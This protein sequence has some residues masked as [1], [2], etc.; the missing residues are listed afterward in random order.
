MMPAL[1][2]LAQKIFSIIVAVGSAHDDV[3]MIPV[4][5][6]EPWK[7]LAGLVIKFDDD[8]R[9]MN[10]VEKHAVFFNAAAPGKIRITNIP[11]HFFHPRLHR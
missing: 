1:I 8:D 5:V 11:L 7:R 10:A 4:M 9:A 3:Y 2:V 6:F